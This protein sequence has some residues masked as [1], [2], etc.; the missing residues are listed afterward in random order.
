MQLVR[1]LQSSLAVQHRGLWLHSAWPTLIEQPNSGPSSLPRL[2]QVQWHQLLAMPERT[3]DRRVYGQSKNQPGRTV[4][5]DAQSNAPSASFARDHGCAIGGRRLF[6][7][8]RSTC[9]SPGWAPRFSQ[10]KLVQL[11]PDAQYLAFNARTRC[12]FAT[13]VEALSAVTP[14][15]SLNRTRNGIRLAPGGTRCAHCAPPGASRLPPRAG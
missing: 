14:N 4:V 6:P 11:G 12:D 1:Q 7:P 5:P 9:G 10:L 13:T 15:T 8:N 3:A 2:H